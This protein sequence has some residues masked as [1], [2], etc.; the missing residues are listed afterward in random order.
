MAAPRVTVAPDYG[1]HLRA[2][3]EAGGGQLTEL[4]EA[5]VLVWT[6]HDDP[7]GLAA[8]L[9][10]QPSLQWIAL[11]WA[12]IEPYV[13]AGLIDDTRVW[14]SAKGVYAGPVAEHALALSLAGM[15]ELQ[16]WSRARSWGPEAGISLLGGKVTIF[17]GGG[18]TRA[19]LD[20]LAPFGCE[21][22]VVRRHPEPMPGA[23]RVIGFEQRFEALK[24]ADVVVLA[25]A[26]TPETTGLITS[27]E[28]EVME[29]HA[30]LVNVARGRHVVTVD[31][32]AALIDNTIGGA[33]LDVTEPEPL[34]SGHPLWTLPNVL[35]TPHIGLT[36][37]MARPL[38]AARV[39][40]N[41][42]RW[43]AAEPLLG[44]VNPELGY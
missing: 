32:V 18:V 8:T 39:T 6:E 26:L 23:V 29:P 25:L 31:L 41:I 37:D 40:E 30:W 38:L 35:I 21:V 43:A 44:R 4:A 14:T 36:D 12:G 9:A 5:D 33:A 7:A 10:E 15:R 42:R 19:L 16:R 34:P 28:F 20:L 27:V 1:A 11:P 2:A 3:V 24:G 22:T 13:E 17:G